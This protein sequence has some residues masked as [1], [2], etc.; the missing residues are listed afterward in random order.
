MKT[1]RMPRAMLYSL[2]AVFIMA[3]VSPAL[4]QM[5]PPPGPVATWEFYLTPAF[6]PEH[7]RNQG[8]LAEDVTKIQEIWIE[9]G[10]ASAAL[11]TQ[12]AQKMEAVRVGLW[13]E[14]SQEDFDKAVQEAQDVLQEIMANRFRA[15]QQTREILG[16]KTSEILWNTAWFPAPG[17]MAA[18]GQMA[19]GG[20]MGPRGMGPGG[21]GPGG[22]GPHGMGPHGMGPNRP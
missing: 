20:M 15:F 4:A 22:M 1:M 10:K 16:D 11:L 13:Q 8:A 14:T 5:R 12:Y 19:P 9:E 3:I 17:P 7:L 21:M 18:P 2:L 6:A